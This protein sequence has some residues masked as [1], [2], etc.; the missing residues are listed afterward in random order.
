[1]DTRYTLDQEDIRSINALLSEITEKYKPVEDDD[2][3]RNACLYSHELPRPLRAFMNDF[4]MREN[5]TGYCIISGYPVDETEIGPTPKHWKDRDGMPAPLKEQILLILL[6]SLLGEVF[7]WATQQAG[8]LVHNVM[9][10][11]EHEEE[12]LGTGSKQLL[13]WHIED[14]FH[15][16]RGDYLG[17]MCLRNPDNVA[18]TVAC[19]N[20][21]ELDERQKQLLFEPHFIIRPDESHLEKNSGMTANEI[22]IA[23][24]LS[25]QSY[26]NIERLNSNPEKISVLFGSPDSPYLRLDP[27]YMLPSDL[28]EAQ[29][30]LESLI[31]SLE[32][33]L[34]E[35]I[36]QPGDYCFIDNFRT[37]HGRKPFQARH[38]G[39]D[40]W[41]KRVNITRDL[42]KSRSSRKTA[43]SRT[44][45]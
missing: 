35:L 9:P 2:F 22:G 12:Q 31:N 23:E 10:I 4:K 25:A 37:V 39:T 11:K 1:M 17:M 6:G 36:L 16:Y 32:N 30:A 19:I 13:W 7:G 38:N 15:P 44:I 24:T 45:L 40:R 29:Q 8:Y 26:K 20:N 34:C 3:M 14:A 33:A 43:L 27:Y 5:Q 18:T 21:I 28:P 41:L 42:R